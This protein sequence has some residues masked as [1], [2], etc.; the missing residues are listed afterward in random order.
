M[1]ILAKLGIASPQRLASFRKYAV[2]IILVLAAL[3]T[4]STDPVNMMIVFVPLYLLY[5]AGILVSR[6]FAQRPL[7]PA[8]PS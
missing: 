5:E 1:F 6:L 7:E 2:L 4:P 8:T 3:I